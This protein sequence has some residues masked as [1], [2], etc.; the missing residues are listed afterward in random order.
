M[1]CP[2]DVVTSSLNVTATLV[3]AAH[4]ADVVLALPLVVL[5]A[6]AVLVG[7]AVV[8]PPGDPPVIAMSAQV[9]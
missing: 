5:D 6:V 3:A 7:A 9:R 2:Y 8:V 4:A 1:V